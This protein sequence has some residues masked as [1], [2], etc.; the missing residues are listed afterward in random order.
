MT[1]EESKQAIFKLHQ[2]Y[3][4]HTSKERLKLYNEYQQKRNEIKE[5]LKKSMQKKKVK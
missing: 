2:E 5:Q 1:E 4:N 3:M